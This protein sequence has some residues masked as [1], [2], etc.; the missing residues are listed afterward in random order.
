MIDGRR[1]E[2]TQG[3]PLESPSRMAP[4]CTERAIE[5]KDTL[6]SS[7]HHL[8]ETNKGLKGPE[9]TQHLDRELMVQTVEEAC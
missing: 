2:G 9:M 4:L 6:A 7:T 1:N 5:R 8:K 3:A